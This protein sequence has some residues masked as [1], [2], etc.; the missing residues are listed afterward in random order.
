MV[1]R[2]LALIKPEAVESKQT[3]KIIDL[4]EQHGFTIPQMYKI[5]ATQEMAEKFYGVHKEKPFFGELVGNISAGP[6]VALVLEK[7]NAIADWRKL[8][9]ATDPQKAEP[10]TI[11]KLFGKNISFNTV[12]G[13]DAPETAVFELKVF[14]PNLK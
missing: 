8:M 9:G 2:T 11:R 4:I 10:G 1:Q 7:E 3:G 6:L 13:S 5:H 12:H 14:F